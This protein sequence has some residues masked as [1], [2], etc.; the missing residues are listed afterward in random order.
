MLASTLPGK[1][2]CCS[3]RV[4][5]FSKSQSAFNRP[6]VA[7]PLKKGAAVLSD[8]MPEGVRSPPCRTD[9]RAA[10]ELGRLKAVVAGDNLFVLVDQNWR[11]RSNV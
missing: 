8:A 3:N 6:P 4:R 1:K 9:L 5:R 10:V 2:G 11:I 7:T